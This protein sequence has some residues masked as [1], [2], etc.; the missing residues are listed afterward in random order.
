MTPL[1]IETLL[2]LLEYGYLSCIAVL[3]LKVNN[4]IKVLIDFLCYHKS[5]CIYFEGIYFIKYC[6]FFFPVL[7][8]PCNF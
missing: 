7:Y 5:L 2:D 6:V 1:F 8:D 3:S 4:S